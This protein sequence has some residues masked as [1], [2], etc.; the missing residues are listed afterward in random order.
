MDSP[1]RRVTQ[2]S[3]HHKNLNTLSTENHATQLMV[4]LSK[5]VKFAPDLVINI[6]SVQ[7]EQVGC[8]GFGKYTNEELSNQQEPP[9][10]SANWQAESFY[11]SQNLGGSNSIGN[12][13]STTGGE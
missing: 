8:K 4:K 6:F 9:L 3:S 11:F 13:P 2:G 5:K 1:P 12:T 10:M 7:L